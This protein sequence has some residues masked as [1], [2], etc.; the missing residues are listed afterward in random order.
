MTKDS[1]QQVQAELD[2]ALAATDPATS[3]S[4]C[5]RAQLLLARV[6][7]TQAFDAR[8]SRAITVALRDL[9]DATGPNAPVARLQTRGAR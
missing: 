2:A 5:R 7:T 9:R 1:Y 6:A 4:A 3:A 8:R